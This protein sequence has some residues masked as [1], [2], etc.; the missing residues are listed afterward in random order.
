MLN[1]NKH[2]EFQN[3]SI[4]IIKETK[5]QMLTRQ[6]IHENTRKRPKLWHLTNNE[7]LKRRW[8]GTENSELG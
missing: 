7:L 8:K 4:F 2:K 3:K 1:A 5:N 6:Q